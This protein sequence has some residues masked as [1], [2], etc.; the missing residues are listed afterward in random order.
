[1]LKFLSENKFTA[2]SATF[3]T[4]ISLYAYGPLQNSYEGALNSKVDMGAVPPS[5]VLVQEAMDFDF[6]DVSANDDDRAFYADIIRSRYNYKSPEAQLSDNSLQSHGLVGL[7]G[8]L[9]VFGAAALGR[10]ADSPKTSNDI[11]EN[12][13]KEWDVDDGT[14]FDTDDY[15]SDPVDLDIPTYIRNGRS[16]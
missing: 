12:E 3:A 2:L 14:L 16:L 10:M 7:G 1:M 8:I 9:L 5:P 4:A 13:D 11:P 6:A 15:K